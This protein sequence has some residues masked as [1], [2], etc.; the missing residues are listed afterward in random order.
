M[1]LFPDFSMFKVL[2]G[3]KKAME[4]RL[5]EIMKLNLYIIKMMDKNY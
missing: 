4:I 3:K 1:P 5:F 2:C